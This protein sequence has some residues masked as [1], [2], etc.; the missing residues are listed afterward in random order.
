MNILKITALMG[1]ACLA[2]FLGYTYVTADPPGYCSAQKRYISDDEF[3]R[4]V[5]VLVKADIKNS[6]P[7]KGDSSFYG[8]WDGYVPDFGDSTYFEVRREETHSIFNRMFGQQTVQV[9][10]TPPSNKKISYSAPS[11]Y[12]DVCGTLLESDIGLPSSNAQYPITTSTV[13]ENHGL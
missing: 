3:T 10:I 1:T 6:K 13:G 4:T 5:V 12:F 9:L 7:K 8:N 2:V 11:F